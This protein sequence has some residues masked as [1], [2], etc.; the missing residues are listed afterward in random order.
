[1]GALEIAIRS[2]DFPATTTVDGPVVI[3]WRNA[4]G[5]DHDVE[6]GVGANLGTMKQGGTVQRRF[7]TPGRFSYYCTFHDDM[8]GV[9][10]VR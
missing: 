9:I 8:A 2:N 5:E 7:D 10:V 6:F 1:M 4:S 3:T